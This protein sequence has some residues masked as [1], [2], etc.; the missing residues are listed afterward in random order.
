MNLK[1]FLN[2]KIKIIFSEGGRITIYTGRIISADETSLIFEDKYKKILSLA[3]SAIIKM[4][5]LDEDG[6]E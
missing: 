6:R 4:E 1:P 2:Q 3:H 5:I